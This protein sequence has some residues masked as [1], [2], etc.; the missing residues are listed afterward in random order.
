MKKYKNIILAALIAYVIYYIFT[1]IQNPPLTEEQ[2]KFIKDLHPTVQNKFRSFIREVEEKT[3]YK[4]KITS[5]HRGWA[6]SLRI[7]QTYPDV[8]KCCQ[9]GK[10]FHFFGL[11]LDLGLIHPTTGEMLTMSSPAEKWQSTGVGE[12]AK[13]YNLRWGI[14]FPGYYDPIHFDYG[15]YKMADL[16][17]RAEQLNGSLQNTQGNRMNLTGIQ[18]TTG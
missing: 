11:A 14:Y 18:K 8:Q 10:D 1:K 13:K 3:K 16:V 15:V 5:G 2:E 12:I 4:V 6:D 17:S 9:P 7:W